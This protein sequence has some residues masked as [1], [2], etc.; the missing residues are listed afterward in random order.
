MKEDKR[1]GAN[2]ARDASQGKK[3]D[4]NTIAEFRENKKQELITDLAEHF[5]LDELEGKIL[6]DEDKIKLRE[7]IRVKLLDNKLRPKDEIVVELKKEYELDEKTEI[8]NEARELADN[9][10]IEVGAKEPENSVSGEEAE[11]GNVK[12]KNKDENLPPL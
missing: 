10:L 3:N 2:K 8:T 7:E 6:L 4:G 11:R 1:L 5:V 12:D 9:K